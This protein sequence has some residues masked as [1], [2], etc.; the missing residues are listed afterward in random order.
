MVC[1]RQI[2]HGHLFSLEI[3]EPWTLGISTC[4]WTKLF[5]T[6]SVLVGLHFWEPNETHFPIQKLKFIYVKGKGP[7][8][9][10]V[11]M[12]LT[13]L[14]P[15]NHLFDD[16]QYRKSSKIAISWPHLPVT[17]LFYDVCN[18]WM[19]PN[20]I[21]CWDVWSVCTCQQCLLPPAPA[22]CLANARC[23]ARCR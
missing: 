23:A 18:T 7:F 8:K 9:Y 16:L 2:F 21:S 3:P 14:G 22:S 13:F 15:P 1:S 19:V 12:F 6:I 4:T 20:V 11:I 5:P 10:Y 17:H